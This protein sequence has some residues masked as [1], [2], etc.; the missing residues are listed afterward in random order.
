MRCLRILLTLVSMLGAG[1]SVAAESFLRSEPPDVSTP[2]KLRTCRTDANCMIHAGLAA[3]LSDAYDGINRMIPLSNVYN[4]LL[5]NGADR[6]DLAYLEDLMRAEADRLMAERGEG[7]PTFS[8]A[9]VKAARIGINLT[10]TEFRL[11]DFWARFAEQIAAHNAGKRAINS[12]QCLTVRT[13][14]SGPGLNRHLVYEDPFPAMPDGDVCEADL[15]KLHNGFEKNLD[16]LIERAIGVSKSDERERLLGRLPAVALL[17]HIHERN[18][19]KDPAVADLVLEAIAARVRQNRAFSTDQLRAALTLFELG[20]PVHATDMLSSIDDR[21][22]ERW[23]LDLVTDV[24]VTALVTRNERMIDYLR[25]ALEERLGPSLTKGRSRI[26][27]VAAMM[28]LA[29]RF[30]PKSEP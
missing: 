23:R 30:D 1:A 29:V 7:D 27:T 2:E 12:V 10:P 18:R 20:Y 22:R 13:I 6:E 8:N 3:Y 4:A 5:L 21:M 24:F 11:A 16:L 9:M 15:E 17:A 19:E 28:Y 26:A 25:P 14:F